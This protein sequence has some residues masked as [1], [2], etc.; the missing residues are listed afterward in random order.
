MNTVIVLRKI[1]F[2]QILT[3]NHGLKT[4]NQRKFCSDY[5]AKILSKNSL[6]TFFTI[7]DTLINT[8]EKCVKDTFGQC[9][10][11]TDSTY[12]GAIYV[13]EKA[14]LRIGTHSPKEFYQGCGKQAP[15][16]F[17]F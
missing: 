16:Q 6:Y 3:E 2:I 17:Y 8:S 15:I 7:G 1:E 10:E 12:Y 11:K 4:F 5:F 14:R 13:C 9:L